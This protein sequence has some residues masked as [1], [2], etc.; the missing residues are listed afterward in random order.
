MA[1]NFN[2]I[3]EI[4]DEMS[5]SSIDRNERYDQYSTMNSPY[6]NLIDGNNNKQLV[7]KHYPQQQ[8]N[9]IGLKLVLKRQAN[10]NYKITN[11]SDLLL[12]PMTTE[13]SSNNNNNNLNKDARIRPKRAASNKVK[14]RFSEEESEYENETPHRKRAKLNTKTVDNKNF[15]KDI[16]TQVKFI[17]PVSKSKQR[18]QKQQQVNSRDAVKETLNQ[19]SHSKQ[20]K[21]LVKKFV[22]ETLQDFNRNEIIEST[23]NEKLSAFQSR[24]IVLIEK[25][26]PLPICLVED[27]TN[28][29][30]TKAL[31]FIH[32]FQTFSAQCIGCPLCK[33]YLNI[34]EFSKHIH[35]NEDDE[36]D[37]SD[38]EKK[39]EITSNHSDMDDDTQSYSN[40]KTHIKKSYKILP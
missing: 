4:D 9:T 30:C 19:L 12:L 10:N 22:K 27:K 20:E 33:I 34:T 6:S 17:Y 13:V 2:Q 38:S 14:F 28:I 18:Q 3:I 39:S 8:Q 11:P 1:D 21:P 36:D 29:V 24:P 32:L 25:S 40:S 5:S 15:K 37:E 31:L 7:N 16:Q 35:Q 26:Q 23:Y